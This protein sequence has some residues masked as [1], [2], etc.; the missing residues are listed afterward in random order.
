MINIKNSV[1]NLQNYNNFNINVINLNK[2]KFID[3]DN[4]NS[5]SS[6]IE[7]PSVYT[8]NTLQKD[9]I[10]NQ[11]RVRSISVNN[12]LK[13]NKMKMNSNNC[14]KNNWNFNFRQ[15][16]INI[17]E[18]HRQKS[19][20]YDSN[21]STIKDS[22]SIKNI[23]IE[24]NIRDQAGR[25]FTENFFKQNPN[26]NINNYF[27]ASSLYYN[28]YKGINNKKNDYKNN[29]YKSK[30]P[31]DKENS[32][33]RKRAKIDEI[34]PFNLKENHNKNFLINKNNNF[35]KEEEKITINTVENT[36]LDENEEIIG[37]NLPH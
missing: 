25:T 20:N 5:S 26:N 3:N 37:R 18:L 30:R 33:F 34:K 22:N 32:L 11:P 21:I 6:I 31:V 4:S 13:K 12:A 2:N 35:S 10:I 15:S 7:E 1:N 16:I 14:N 29:F 19:T 24:K 27:T 36:I 28:N 17:N 8:K 9:T 23:Q